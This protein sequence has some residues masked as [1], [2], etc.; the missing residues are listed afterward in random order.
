MAFAVS[1]AFFMGATNPLVAATQSTV[2][3]AL[4]NLA[5]MTANYWQG[6]V[7]EYM[8]YA[9]VFFI[10]VVVV[11]IPL[12]LIPFLRTREEIID[13]EVLV[14]RAEQYAKP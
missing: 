10:E 8:G 4:G 3:L 1:T 14:V 6:F 11:I 2:Y 5:I 9:N 12:M 7:S 13:K